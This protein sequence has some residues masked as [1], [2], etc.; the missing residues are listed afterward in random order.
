MYAFNTRVAF[1]YR[2]DKDTC[3]CI[4]PFLFVSSLSFQTPATADKACELHACGLNRYS[5]A[6]E[7]GPAGTRN[8]ALSNWSLFLS[9]NPVLCL[10]LSFIRDGYL[11]SA[12][13]TVRN[14]S[15]AAS[16]GQLP[17]GLRLAMWLHCSLSV[18]N[19]AEE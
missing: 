3:I 17:K 6:A 19:C 7:R 18:D 4:A 1:C 11:C 5:W 13:Q 14:H 16:R 9:G 2:R 10:L 12:L 8:I 15:R